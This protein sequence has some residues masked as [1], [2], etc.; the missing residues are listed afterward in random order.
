MGMGGKLFG[1][2]ALGIMMRLRHFRGREDLGWMF[3][4][5]KREKL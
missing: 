5:K 2:S 4:G 1:E 3:G